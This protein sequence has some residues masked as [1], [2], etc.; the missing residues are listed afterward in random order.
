M[1]NNSEQKVVK[2]N[3]A[4]IFIPLIL[5]IVIIIIGGWYWY[6]DYAKFITTDDAFIDAD[7]VAVSSKILGRITE[8]YVQ[9]GDSVKKGEL[10]AEL[11]SVELKAQEKQSFSS[12]DQAYAMK[13]QSE[14]KFNLDEESITVQDINF[15]K[16]TDD[17]NRAKAQF[18]GGVITK[19]AMEH[20]QKSFESEK[21]KLEE[22]KTQLTVSKTQILSAQT[23]IENAEAQINVIETQLNNCRLYSP[24]DGVVSKRW[25]LAGDITQPGQSIYTLTN[26]KNLWITIYLEETNMSQ[27]HIN[28][29]VKFTID[30]FEGVTFNGNLFSIGT[31]TAS[32]FS[33]IPPNNAS[34]N[35]TKVTQR[36]PV[37]VSI[38]SC[39]KGNLSSYSLLSGMSVVAKMYKE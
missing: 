8:L 38:K 5:V 6:S 13:Q 2:K 37:K 15:Q 17:Y 1:E 11:D 22:A 34:G 19:E 28:Q 35:F 21:V 25:L 18:E 16:V 7:K 14:A 29:K 12:R 24:L 26:N 3:N 10:L 20:I 4:K 39:D 9:E 23:G 36:I 30:A 27:V 32:Q 31:N 33:L